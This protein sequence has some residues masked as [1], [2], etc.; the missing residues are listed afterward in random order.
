MRWSKNPENV[1]GDTSVAVEDAPKG[2]ATTSPL[3]EN[4][5]TLKP[6]LWTSVVAK[7]KPSRVAV[8]G[9]K[10]P[11]ER[12]IGV[13]GVQKKHPD[14][15][16]P[17]STKPTDPSNV[18]P[19]SPSK[20]TGPPL[21]IFPGG[22]NGSNEPLL[23]LMVPADADR[24]KTTNAKNARDRTSAN[25]IRTSVSYPLAGPLFVDVSV[26]TDL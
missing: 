3:M 21:P 6:P 11:A 20:C 23:R 5:R 16:D 19:R 17:S 14:T 25:R 13:P 18:N 12:W 15:L 24:T 2:G 9:G 10:P 26:L 1:S 7:D 22:G 8:P 4:P